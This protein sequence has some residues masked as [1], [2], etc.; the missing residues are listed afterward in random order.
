MKIALVVLM[1]EEAQE[2]LGANGLT[3]TIMPAEEGEVLN[4]R[5][6]L[7]QLPSVEGVQAEILLLPQLLAK[8]ILAE[9]REEL[10]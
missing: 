9:E 1:L 5:Q 3:E 7:P 2:G 4:L 10:E 8:P 6:L